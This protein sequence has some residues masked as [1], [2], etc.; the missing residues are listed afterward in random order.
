MTYQLS[1]PLLDENTDN[2]QASHLLKEAKHQL[3]FIPNLYAVMA[4]LPS[5]LEVYRLGDQQFRQTSGFSAMEQEIIYL[6]ISIV[7]D[8][9]Y[10]VA[11][12]RT[13][14]AKQAQVPADIIEAICTNQTLKD[15][16]LQALVELTRHVVE[17]RGWIEETK[18]RPFFEAGYT[19][20]QLLAIILAVGIKTLSNY[21]N[22]V[23]QTPIDAA[24]HH[25]ASKPT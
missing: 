1:L 18:A 2:P 23:A 19:E 4:N 7:N 20:P 11:A 13:L 8:C 10:C 22:H 14:A 9:H 17:A 3:G 25:A 15:N 24:F 6:T 21:T 16:K 12:H 5:L